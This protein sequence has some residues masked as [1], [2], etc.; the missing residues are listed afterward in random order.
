MVNARYDALTSATNF[1]ATSSL[2]VQLRAPN[3]NRVSIPSSRPSATS[4]NL[5]ALAGELATDDAGAMAAT[6]PR[7]VEST[8]SGE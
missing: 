6:D 2:T 5:R 4:G 3:R 1:A 8:P 7:R